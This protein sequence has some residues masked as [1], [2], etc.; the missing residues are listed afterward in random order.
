[1]GMSN[2]GMGVLRRFR[3]RDMREV[4]ELPCVEDA[5]AIGAA[6]RLE[7]RDNSSKEN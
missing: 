3:T 5:I 2:S 1:M 7:C 4:L 6:T